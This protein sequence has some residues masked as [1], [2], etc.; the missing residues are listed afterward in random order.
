M[1]R[2]RGAGRP[3]DETERVPTKL[4]L[5]LGLL[6]CG[7]V[8]VSMVQS[9]GPTNTEFPSPDGAYVATIRTY[10]YGAVGGAT[11]VLLR[12]ADGSA[13]ATVIATGE[14]KGFTRL[15]WTGPHS[16]TVKSE[17]V[18]PPDPAWRQSWRKVR[19]VYVYDKSL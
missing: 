10:D 16:L 12:P 5:G 4:G 1:G 2:Q 19:I 11:E 18:E 15:Q 17:Y 13:D 8:L 6:I 14:W 3:A 9:C 7:V